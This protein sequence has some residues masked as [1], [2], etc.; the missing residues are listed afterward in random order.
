MM[1]AQRD[2]DTAVSLTPTTTPSTWSGGAATA[3]QVS[4]DEAVALL[5]SVSSLLDLAQTAVNDL[6]ETSTEC[7]A[8]SVDG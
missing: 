5:T 7:K 6:P 3:F 4:L 1:L 2:Y 8:M